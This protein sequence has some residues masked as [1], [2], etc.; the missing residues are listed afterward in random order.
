MD[1]VTT[2]TH[3]IH[4]STLLYAVMIPLVGSLWVMMLKDNPNLREFTSSAASV[5]LFVVVLSFIPTL[6]AGNTLW[7]RL[8][9]LLPGLDITLRADGFSMI[10]LLVASFLWMIA[11]FYSMGYLRGLHEHAQTRFNACFALA[12]FGAVGVALADNLFTLYLFYEIGTIC[13]Y[14]LVAHH[15]DAKGYA[16]AGKYII[17]L[18]TSARLLLLPAMILIYV[19]VGSLDFPHNIHTGMLPADTKSWLVTMLYIFCLLGFAKNCIMPLHHWLSGITVAPTPV[20]ALFHAVAVVKVGVFCTIRTMLYVFG[21]DAMH[22]LGLGIATACFVSFTII[23]A[24]VIALCKDDLK[25]RLACSTISQLS[26]IILG[27]AL[28]TRHGIEGGLIHIVNHAFSIITLFFAAGAIHVVTRKKNISEMGGL[29]RSMPFTFGA[30]AVASLSMIGVP[31]TAG[32][33]TRWYLLVGS[34]EAHQIGILLV[35]IT[36]MVLNVGYLA[37]V[38]CQAFFGSRPAGEGETG[39]REAPLSMLVPLLIAAAVSVFIGFCPDF[40]MQFVRMVTR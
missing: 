2:T 21:V 3:I 13:T 19:L 24:S 29:G 10:F 32:F 35:L 18:T 33:V 12:V 20:L 27:V 1:A 36:S 23:M 34:M 26:C 30:F 6:R 17:Y 22:R 9:H 8:F 28:L 40:M 39:I 25:T 16:G 5:L 38:T 14:P 37:P 15:Q 31:P 4:S 11:V 7:Y